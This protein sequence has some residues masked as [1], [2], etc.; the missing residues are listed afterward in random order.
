MKAGRPSAAVWLVSLG[1]LALLLFSMWGAVAAWRMAGP[2]KMG[3]HGYIAMAL[4]AV[5]TLL[6]TTGFLWLAYFSARR[7]YDDAQGCGGWAG[8]D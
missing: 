3:M 4:A 2:V 1:L 6:F 8:E 7:G 5:F